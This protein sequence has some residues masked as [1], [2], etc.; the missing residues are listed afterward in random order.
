MN[1]D[2]G[3]LRAIER[4]QGISFNEL[5]ETIA[6]ALLWAYRDYRE[7]PLEDGSRARIDIDTDTGDVTVIVTEL[8]DDGAVISEYDDTPVNFSRIGAV[9][10]RD[11]IKKQLRTAEA[12]SLI[13]I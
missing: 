13:H 3:A 7:H 6:N 11:A 12:L 10:V 8:D 9:A 4:D 1:I 2:M 5:L